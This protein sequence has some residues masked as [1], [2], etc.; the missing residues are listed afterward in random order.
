MK[1]AIVSVSAGGAALSRKIADVL[2]GLGFKGFRYSFAK[3]AAMENCE[4]F[5]NLGELAARL[6][7]ENCGALVFVC[8]CGIAVRAVAPHLKSKAA[9]PAVVVVDDMGRFAVPIL[10]GHLG[11]ANRIAELI[12]KGIGAVPVI[13][14]ATDVRGKFSPD[15]FAKANDLIIGDLGTAKEIAAAVLSGEKIGLISNYQYVNIPTE[16]TESNNYRVGIV[17]SADPHCK[18]FEVT[19]NLI[20]RNIIIGIGCKR[21]TSA[22]VIE[23]R[24][25]S[26]LEHAE[27][28]RR[29]VKVLASI[30]LK[31][32]ERG[33]CEFS[34][35]YG[36]PIRFF[37][38]AE[39]M[40]AAGDFSSSDFVRRTT[41]ADNVCERAAVCCG[42]RLVL[43][44]TA[45]EGVT[46]AAAELSTT[47]DFQR[48]LFTL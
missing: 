10:S 22:E 1:A 13:T 36:I 23:R 26:E 5:S 16:L 32:D 37:S 31:A 14:T 38:A 28:D 35:K 40:S 25:F 44:K 8:S 27:I 2:S 41:G 7:A 47:I 33:L 43:R 42:G 11:G 30:D 21:G 9:D 39:L 15:S 3:Y 48:E 4:P 20:P 34:Q 17:I 45:G 29:R 12:A 19:L 6:F 46:I 18:P 24:V